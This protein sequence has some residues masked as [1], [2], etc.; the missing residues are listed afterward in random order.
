MKRIP[1]LDLQL[2]RLGVDLKGKPSECFS[3]LMEVG[4]TTDRDL[5]QAASIVKLGPVSRP[6]RSQDTS[7]RGGADSLYAAASC[8][9]AVIVF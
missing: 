6:W 5:M 1:R 8:V 3:V 4:S 7:E 9:R 2:R